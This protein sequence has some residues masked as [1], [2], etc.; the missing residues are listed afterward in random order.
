VKII[1]LEAERLS[2]ASA[3]AVDVKGTSSNRV[4]VSADIG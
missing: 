2:S 3:L 4:A 1:L